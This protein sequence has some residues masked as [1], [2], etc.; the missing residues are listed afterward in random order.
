M[1][2]IKTTIEAT[3]AEV[4]AA[5]RAHADKLRAERGFADGEA[6]SIV[7]RTM[8]AGDTGIGDIAVVTGSPG[9]GAVSVVLV[10]ASGNIVSASLPASH[11]A[12]RDA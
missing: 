5:L 4:I 10:H 11:L 9:P 12:K 1:L 2:Q 3:D 6:V 8:I 7:E